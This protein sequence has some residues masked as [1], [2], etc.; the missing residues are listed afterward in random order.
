M[1]WCPRPSRNSLPLSASLITTQAL[2]S[3]CLSHT[4]EKYL[5]QRNEETGDDLYRLEHCLGAIKSP[6]FH[7]IVSGCTNGTEQ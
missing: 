1:I 7:G 5:W 6:T 4:R 2:R 3:P